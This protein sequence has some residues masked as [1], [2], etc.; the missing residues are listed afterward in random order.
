MVNSF[1]SMSGDGLSLK[2]NW[3][4]E[5]YISYIP[6]F[7]ACT[8]LF[9]VSML[10]IFLIPVHCCWFDPALLVSIPYVF[11]FNLPSLCSCNPHV[12]LLNY[13]VPVP[14][15]LLLSSPFLRLKSLCLEPNLAGS[16]AR[17]GLWPVNGRSAWGGHID[18]LGWCLDRS[19]NENSATKN[20]DIYGYNSSSYSAYVYVKSI[21]IVAT[22]YLVVRF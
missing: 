14:S 5:G 2:T 1:T 15:F 20:G 3:K 4:H 12:F 7:V 11:P 6:I 18:T 10:F 19:K 17:S 13:W 21:F 16:I 22:I 9:R 8:L